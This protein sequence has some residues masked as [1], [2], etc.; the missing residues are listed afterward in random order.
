MDGDLPLTSRGRFKQGR[1]GGKA[2]NQGLPRGGEGAGRV[3]R[4]ISAGKQGERR[5]ITV[6][7]G[8][9]RERKDY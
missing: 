5:L 9:S 2:V 8:E 4:D 6:Y 1:T 3:M 7:R